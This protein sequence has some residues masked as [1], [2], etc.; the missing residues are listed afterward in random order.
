[1]KKTI[2]F[3]IAILIGVSVTGQLVG[4]GLTPA[5]AYCGTITNAQTWTFS[6]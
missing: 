5:T 1:M 6:L 3:F 4:D 2:L